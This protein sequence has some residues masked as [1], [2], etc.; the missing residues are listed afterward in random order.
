MLNSQAVLS[1]TLHIYSNS[2]SNSNLGDSCSKYYLSAATVSNGGNCGDMLNSYGVGLVASTMLCVVCVVSAIFLVYSSSMAIIYPTDRLKFG[3]K[4]FNSQK[5]KDSTIEISPEN[6]FGL[7][8]AKYDGE[9]NGNKYGGTE[10]MTA[11]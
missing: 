6:D 1:L 5:R 8:P 10:D 2:N 11:W 7:S 4:N 9:K 3:F